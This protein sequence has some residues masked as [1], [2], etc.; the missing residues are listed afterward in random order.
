MRVASR[1][2][3]GP[4]LL[5]EYEQYDYSLDLWSCGCTMGTMVLRRDP[6]FHGHDNVDQLVKIVQI[7]GSQGLDAY[8]A[9]Y[10][11]DL[12][13]E[14]ARALGGADTSFPRKPW[15][16]FVNSDNERYISDDALDLLDKLLKYDHQ[17]RPTAREAMQHPYFAGVRAA[18]EQ[19]EA[20]RQQALEQARRASALSPGAQPPGKPLVTATFAS[21]DLET[22]EMAQV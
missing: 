11:I 19:R 6:L 9:K 10:R 14:V 1:Y 17:E 7:L 2:Y 3:K 13:I 5:V 18:E 22:V 21:A 12:P 20:E 15:R 4:E 16:S 8:L